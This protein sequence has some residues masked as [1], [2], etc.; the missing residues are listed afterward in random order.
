MDIRDLIEDI[1]KPQIRQPLWESWYIKEKIGSGAFSVVYR[2]EAERPYGTDEAALK[3][4]A[5]TVDNEFV[6]DRSLRSST[7]ETKRQLALNEAKHM[8]AL[9]D[10]P[11][12]VRYEEEHFDA[13]YA[14]EEWI[15]YY[16]L[17]RMELLQTV[18]ALIRANEFQCT[19]QNVMKLASEIG[20]GLKAAHDINV[21][22]RDIKPENLFRSKNGTFKLGDFN[23]SKKAVI[24]RSFAGAAFYMAPEIY[25]AKVHAEEG[26]TKQADI[27]SLGICLYQLMNDGLLPFEDFMPTD[28]A[29]D[30]RMQ[31]EPL[32]PPRHASP[33]FAKIILTAC[34]Y[35]TADRY[36]SVDS[37]LSD[38]AVVARHPR[39][40]SV[41]NPF[42]GC[43]TILRPNLNPIPK[44]VKEMPDD[45]R[46]TIWDIG[47]LELNKE[48]EIKV[49]QCASVLILLF[50]GM[51]G[52]VLVKLQEPMVGNAELS[53]PL[54]IEEAEPGA[55]YADP[56]HAAKG[57]VQAADA[58]VMLRQL[59]DSGDQANVITNLPQGADIT[60][61][62]PFQS[63]FDEN[64]SDW[65]YVACSGQ[66]GFIPADAVLPNDGTAEITDAQL[67]DIAKLLY[68]NAM[69]AEF[70]SYS[71]CF[72]YHP[73]TY[74]PHADVRY[75]LISDVYTK[76]DWLAQIHCSFSSQYD[77]MRC[78]GA[79]L[80]TLTQSI[81]GKSPLYLES[82]GAWYLN[83][84][85]F[86]ETDILL[87]VTADDLFA[88]IV[89]TKQHSEAQEVFFSGNLNYANA[90]ARYRNLFAET[91]PIGN[92]SIRFENGQWKV[93][94]YQDARN[95]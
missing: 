72:R 7:L 61:L 64:I 90:P 27:Y 24:T 83:N 44:D 85:M 30:R 17:I 94:Y 20:Q 1:I 84:V 47:N 12:I 6:T 53:K 60:L 32:V 33:E 36:Q 42:F 93:G 68:F 23:I 3:I 25:R 78:G 26:Y 51:L 29:I 63:Y 76:Q 14:D 67:T 65:Y 18:A 9:R 69:R 75:Y 52:F 31:G 22:H 39:T 59:P 58:D 54:H 38:L 37:M 89:L 10:C 77:G 50:C 5:I 28:D 81:D 21:I 80:D 4:Q 66:T 43:N 15:G 19:E 91:Y 82:D 2:M 95:P 8:K 35:E 74:I 48:W 62:L 40:R 13:L 46:K 55:A 86:R 88:M 16:F 73:D 57:T 41:L 45:K 49:F 87:D 70:R 11:Y 71:Q 92:F 56:T 34:A 79:G